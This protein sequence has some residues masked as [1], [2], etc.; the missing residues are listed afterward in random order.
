MPGNV[1][2]FDAG[3]SIQVHIEKSYCSTA[4][5]FLHGRKK[6]ELTDPSLFSR[7]THFFPLTFTQ[8]KASGTYPYQHWSVNTKNSAL[9]LPFYSPSEWMS[10]LHVEENT[11]LCYM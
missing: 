8:S 10:T 7:T 11:L 4:L 2:T 6:A 5:Y 3:A 9:D 1:R